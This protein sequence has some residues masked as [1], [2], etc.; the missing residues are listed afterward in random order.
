VKVLHVVGTRPNFMKIAP[1][2]A[3]LSGRSGV[4]QRLVHTAQHYD[5]DMSGVFL[6]EM[7]LPHPDYF[8]GVG[9]GTH[10]T[11]GA[12][13]IVGVERVVT[14]ERPDV[15]VVPGDV[16]STMGAAIAAVKLEVPVAHVEAG[17]RSYDRSMPEE[18]NRVI[19][20]HLAELLLTPSRDA[21]ENL[22]A[23]GIPAERIRFVGNVMIDSL[24][25]YEDRAR[26]L[27]VGRRELGVED[28]LL[29]TLHRPSLVDDAERLL[30]VM[31][32][33]ERIA[34]HRPV[35]FPVHPRTAAMLD[36]Q[37]WEQRRVRLL[38]PQGY[39]RFLSLLVGASAVLTDS[40]GIQ[41]ETTVLG[42][43]CFTLRDTTERPITVSEGTNCVLG[44]GSEGLARFE[45]LL[46]SAAPAPGGILEGWDGQ[47]G[48]RAADA[49]LDRFGDVQL[50]T[51]PRLERTA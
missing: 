30:E 23:E 26:E 18:H 15:V 12:K 47:A 50:A 17:L 4:E 24:R 42:V 38:E 27:D 31:A 44:T 40:G 20:D 46:P 19:A 16:N 9:P 6:D 37:G 11:Q 36:E 7:D 49:L 5:R 2:M 25:R 28:H 51:G 35:I 45:E 14:E 1:L 10:G 8:L 33:L 22:A 48:Q 21:D 3:A 34:E 39:I 41:E 13:V 43:P 29:V 32:A